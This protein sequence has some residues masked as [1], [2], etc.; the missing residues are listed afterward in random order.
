MLFF[1]RFGDLSNYFCTF[2]G[3]KDKIS[4]MTTERKQQILQAIRQKA[5]EITPK[6]SEII[7]F[8]SQARGDAHDGSDWDV[9]ILID[10]DR[11][12]SDDMDEYSYPLREM[13]WDYNEC[14]NPMLF[15]KKEWQQNI[16]SP[17][18]ENV[19]HDGI[20]L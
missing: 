12:T 14:I 15:T 13:G 10:K 16:A 5:K 9:L 19:L 3:R 7:L 11:V 8:G 2:A 18:Y 20:K 4:S 6:G 1:F 17:F